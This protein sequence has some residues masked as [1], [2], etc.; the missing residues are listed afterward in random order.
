MIR[1]LLTLLI[2]TSAWSTTF[3]IQPIEQQIK[4]SDGLFKGQY[5]RSKTIVLENGSLATQMM[6]RMDKEM[7]LESDFYGMNEVIVHYPGGKAVGTEVRV[8]GVPQFVP[9]ESVMLFIRN[10]ENRYWGMNLS[11][12]SFKVINYGN[13]VVL[14]NTLVPQHPTVGQVRWTHFEGLVKKIKGTDLKII[15]SQNYPMNPEEMKTVREPALIEEGQNRTVASESN[16]SDNQ[17]TQ[18][19]RT[20]FWLIMTLGLSGGIFRFMNRRAHE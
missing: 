8:D 5:L 3:Q 7:G 17:G 9:G 2:S 16:Q 13:E 20:V 4:E 15:Q 6:F 18:P 10:V 1:L 11:F 12:G 14:V 19:N